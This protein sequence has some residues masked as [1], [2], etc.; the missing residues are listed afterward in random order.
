MSKLSAF[1]STI[2][3]GR[4]RREAVEQRRSRQ[5]FGVSVAVVV[6]WLVY[7]TGAG[8]WQRVIDQIA[9]AVTMVFGSFVAGSTP[10]GGGA[11]AFP[12][13]T[14]LLRVDA[15]VARSFSLCIQ[16]VGMGTAAAAI[17]ITKR[18][19]EW[20]AVRVA[21]PSA[22]VGFLL[23]AVLLGRS[24]EPFWPSRLPGPYVKV[25]FTLIITATAVVVYIGYRTHLL[26]RMVAMPVAGPRVLTALVV[27]GFVGGL[28]SWL[29]GSGADVSLYLIVVVLIGVSPRVGV[30]TSVVLMAGISIVGFFLLGIVDGQLSVGIDAAGR[31]TELGGERIGRLDAETI[32]YGRG[33]ALDSSRYD[34]F[35]LWLAAVPVVAFGAPLGAWAVSKTTDRQLVRFVV[36]LAA[37]ETVSTII[38]LDGLVRSPDV[39]LIVYTIVGAVVIIGGLWMFQRFRRTILGLPAVDLD[40]SFTRSRLDTGPR[41]REQ[42]AEQAAPGISDDLDQRQPPDL[43]STGEQS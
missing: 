16:A 17:V 23:G 40:Q 34:L 5:A 35:G 24:D 41:F 26:E 22:I 13:F 20:R 12:V 15:E 27:T 3:E 18:Q 6:I 31:V 30:P 39:A 4:R 43:K 25:T 9:S 10:Q 42:L 38:F 2:E 21:L 33:A 11:V 37:M 32:R 28:A 14:K 29:V 7:V 36:A 1:E 8:Q 19:V